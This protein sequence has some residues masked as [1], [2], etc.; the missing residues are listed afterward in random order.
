[1]EG[2]LQVVYFCNDAHW[3]PQHKRM[4]EKYWPHINF[5]GHMETLLEDA[6]TLLKQVGAWEEYGST[7]WGVK[8]DQ[9][10]FQAKAGEAGRHHATNARAQLR[11]YLTAELETA[12][13]EYY[14]EDYTNAMMNLTK[15][16]VFD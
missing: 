14:S 7:G 10:V 12:V 6:E 8:G 13:D 3:R 1:M 2:F 9:Y 16:K 15:F 11:S 4:E 5:V